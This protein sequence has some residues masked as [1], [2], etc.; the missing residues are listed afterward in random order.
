MLI[1]LHV[2]NLA[3]IRESDIDFSQMLNILTGET[4]AGKSVLIG[5]IQ[6][7]LGGRIPK[8]M[9]RPGTDSAL[10]ELVFHTENPAVKSMLNEYDIPWEDGEVIISRRVTS[11][12]VINKVNDTTITIGR[13]KELAPLLLDLSG[14]HENQL[15]LKTENHRSILD[16]YAWDAVRPVK[17]RIAA[18]YER[19]TGLER[20]LLEETMGEEE[21]IRE[22]EFLSFEIDEISNARLR[23]GEEEEL[24]E[25]YMRISHAREILSDCQEIHMMMSDGRENASDLAGR[26]VR[27]AADVAEIDAR[28]ESL[29]SQIT[30]I[31]A[32][33]G[34][35]NRE[36]SSY[37]DDMEYDEDTFVLIE[38]RLDL[39][40][41]LKSK[42]GTD[43]KSIFDYKKRSEE[44]REK[45]MH[46]EEHLASLQE[47]FSRTGESLKKECDLLSKLRKEAALPL[48]EQIRKALMDLN[49]LQVRFEIAFEE[50]DR[51]SAEGRDK[52]CF[53]IAP[54][55]GMDLCPLAQI[56]SGGE[57]S[58]IM[59]A[60]KSV[61]ADEEEIETL[62]FDEIDTG[63]SGRTAQ[64]VSEKLALIARKRQV[65]AITHLPQIA[66]MADTHYLI[67]KTSEE[68]MTISH[69]HKLNE[70]EAGKE[71]ARML[72][73][74]RITDA[75]MENA[76]EMRRLAQHYKESL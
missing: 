51:F 24:E 39:I 16:S 25:D 41:H 73:G 27:L 11:Q 14:Q 47:E 32:L 60:I 72:G 50:S 31:D 8:D 71:L 35:F 23:E 38:E 46:Y 13:L 61:L 48:Q 42:Y 10:I 64:K 3:L 63:I 5:S 58:R 30:T 18:L 49:F 70:E 4:G 66:A 17:E 29:L 33:I 26:A 22:I 7:A 67:E 54:N 19:Y 76:V 40:Q 34:D 45:L 62:I 52:V 2:K 75:V 21:R 37:I 20:Q 57:L 68:D 53:M 44:K 65:I 59:L 43:I 12:R 15:L 69:I 74:T 6:S 55:P 56:A 9:I 28:A 1:N 36:L